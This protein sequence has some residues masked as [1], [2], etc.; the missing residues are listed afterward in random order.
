MVLPVISLFFCFHFACLRNLPFQ[1]FPIT[2]QM[3]SDLKVNSLEIF[4]KALGAWIQVLKN[5]CGLLH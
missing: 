3:F 5:E 4:G 1:V 2:S